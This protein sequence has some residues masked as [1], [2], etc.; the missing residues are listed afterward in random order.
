MQNELQ[1][2]RENRK[3]EAWQGSDHRGSE[4]L[5]GEVVGM[6]GR[7]GV[8]KKYHFTWS[9]IAGGGAIYFWDTC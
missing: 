1:S 5:P 7:G 4:G 3:L 2:M 6:W 9:N 8:V